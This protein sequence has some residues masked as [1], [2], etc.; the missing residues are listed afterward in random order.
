MG[1]LKGENIDICFIHIPKT[2]G[3]FIERNLNVIKNILKIQGGQF[4]GHFKIE[5]LP[6]TENTVTFMI[7]RN[8]YERL[9][10][11]YNYLRKGGSNGSDKK[12]WQLLDKPDSLDKF[13]KNIFNYSKN[14]RNKFLKTKCFQ[15]LWTQKSFIQFKLDYDII[16]QSKKDLANEPIIPKQRIEQI[17]NNTKKCA[18]LNCNRFA[19]EKL[20]EN[21]SP[22][23]CCI[24]CKKTP[25]N[26]KH[27]RKCTKKVILENDIINL[28]YQSKFINKTKNKFNSPINIIKYELFQE[29]FLEFANK[30]FS[31]NEILYKLIINNIYNN[32]N[33]KK[34]DNIISKFSDD[35]IK[36]INMLYNEDFK[37][38]GYNMK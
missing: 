8:P 15:H 5:N 3:S 25:N 31:N 11:A 21:E 10:S 35:S 1:L 28:E 36:M 38:F 20:F 16:N 33:V 4:R 29:N 30:Y 22:K 27:G 2:G 6:I 13:I 7:V 18:N 14:N 23:Y 9:Y 34:Y 17:K 26:I 24:L 12:L 32:I 19:N 37:F